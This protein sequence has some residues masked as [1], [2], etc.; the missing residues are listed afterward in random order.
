ME[1]LKN[2]EEAAEALKQYAHKTAQM[3]ALVSSHE[4]AVLQATTALNEKNLPAIN[5]LSGEL[6]ALKQQLEAWSNGNSE[7]FGERRSLEFNYGWL[8]FHQGN[9]K[10]VTL[11]R[12][13]EEKVLKALLAFPVTSQW[14]EYVRREPE[15]N[16]AK[17]P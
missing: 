7:M 9:R 10:L 12:W 3:G 4:K 14:H 1:A 8:K 13:T 6:T 17:L 5:K 15:I 11:A 16:K 2:K